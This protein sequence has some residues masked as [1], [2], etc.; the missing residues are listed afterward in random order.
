METLPPA[1]LSPELTARVQ[2]ITRSAYAH[3]AGNCTQ[4]QKD[5]A[6]AD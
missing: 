4:E 3:W 2:A 1:T 6:L 5:K